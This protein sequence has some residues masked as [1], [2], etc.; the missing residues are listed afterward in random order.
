M[1]K[2]S[3][4]RLSTAGAPHLHAQHSKKWWWTTPSKAGSSAQHCSAHLQTARLHW[5][6]SLWHC[7]FG[8]VCLALLDSAGAQLRLISLL[9]LGWVCGFLE[10]CHGSDV[11]SAWSGILWRTRR[12]AAGEVQSPQWWSWWLP[13]GRNGAKQQSSVLRL[14]FNSLKCLEW[15]RGWYRTASQPH[16]HSSKHL[17]RLCSCESKPKTIFL[18]LSER[19]V[20]YKSHRIRFTKSLRL[21]GTSPSHLVQPCSSTVT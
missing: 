5:F 3:W 12:A 21:K 10:M 16:P 13:Q 1:T 4:Q 6:N 17:T 2:T 19:N 18:I 14:F 15:C 20:R 9:S 7:C 8:P 11:F